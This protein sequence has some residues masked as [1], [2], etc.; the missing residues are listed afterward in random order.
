MSLELLI[1]AHQSDIGEVALSSQPPKVCADVAL[2]VRPL[3]RQIFIHVYATIQKRCC[4]LTFG[5]EVAIQKQ[6][7]IRAKLQRST[8]NPDDEEQT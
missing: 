4:L 2:E 3:Y 5:G 1:L 7:M 8:N 6:F